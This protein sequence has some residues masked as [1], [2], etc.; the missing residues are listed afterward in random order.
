MKN[1]GAAIVV[2]AFML[3]FIMASCVKDEVDLD[4]ISDQVYWNPKFGVPVAYGTLSIADLIEEV[5]STNSITED[6][7]HFLSLIYSN[8]VLSNNAGS[9]LKIQDQQ[10]SEVLL[11]S[12]YNLP[13]YPTQD[14]IRLTRASTDTFQFSNGE[15]IDSIK[16]KAG[17]MAVHVSSTYKQMGSL[18]IIVPK[19]TKNKVPLEILV[20]INKSDGTFS[21]IK[22]Y[23]LTGYKLELE[24]PNG[25]INTMSYNYT[26]KLVNNG[27]GIQAG[28]N[29]KV[30]IDLKD[31]AFS[32]MFGYIG[33]RQ[34]V[35]TVKHFT[36]PLFKDVSN[37]KLQFANPLIRVRSVNSFGVPAN[38][39]LYNVKA[40]SDK[41]NKTVPMVFAS[42]V[43]P[44][45]INHPTK[46]GATSFD[47]AIFDRSTVNIDQALEIGP[48]NIFY[49]IRSF[50]NPAGKAINFVAD[51]SKIKIDLDIEIPLD[52]K[53][54]LLEF[55]DTIDLDLTDIDTEDIKSLILH[56]AFE[57]GMPL[58][59]NM[60]IYLLD[61][62]HRPVDTLFTAAN[63][64]IVKSGTLNQEG[65][66][67]QSSTKETDVIFH[68]S[69][70][71]LLKKV[72]YAM[73]KAGIIT[74]N[75]GATFVKLYSTY[76]LKVN[77]AIQT[78]IEKKD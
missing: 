75:N 57:N 78:E 69:Q 70:L 50:S 55:S 53:T 42:S 40:V 12:Q 31:V 38:V 23:D 32:S 16:M 9:L 8:S 29:I 41:D 27:A 72:K 43:N 47:T 36:V 5:D 15:I 60:Q 68:Q 4:N 22:N 2:I 44:F 67:T 30:T 24:H 18:K 39:E 65:K 28:N 13:A 64:P 46:F 59:L 10:F 51:S 37:P 14:T 62:D 6:A 76:N 3:A 11:E 66:V 35:N 33:Q 54:S 56:T 74:S 52:M 26:A 71:P 63:Q 45:L 58:D 21:T 49:G 25:A 34:L 73:I 7:N 20:D 77:F 61:Q 19:L 17:A 1:S 48:N